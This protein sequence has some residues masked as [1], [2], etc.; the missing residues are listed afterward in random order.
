MLRV[1]V[2]FGADWARRVA[3]SLNQLIL[4]AVLKDGQ[5]T[6]TAPTASATY[7]QTEMQTLM[8]AVEALS[9]RL[10]G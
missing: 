6:Y 10:K 4:K 1:P 2:D 8:D 9:D 5:T 3:T 7:D